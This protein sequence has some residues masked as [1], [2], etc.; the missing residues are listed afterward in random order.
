M[1]LTYAGV[2]G[3]GSGKTTLG[4]VEAGLGSMKI[5][6]DPP[7]SGWTRRVDKVGQTS[8][9]TEM[10][11]ESGD[12]INE[13]ISVYARGINPFASVSY[14]N[15]GNNGG[16]Q[17]GGIQIG[18]PPSAKLPYTIMRDG[19]Y[20]PPVLLQQDL[21][22]LSR[23]PRSIS[24]LSAEARPEMADFTRRLRSCASAAQTK[25]VHTDILHP[26]AQAN[27][28]NP[29]S[30]V[31]AL[32]APFEVKYVVQPTVQKT[33]HSGMRPRGDPT[34][35]WDQLQPGSVQNDPLHAPARTNQQGSNWTSPLNTD[36][37]GGIHTEML[38]GKVRTNQD[39]P[40]GW[41]HSQQLTHPERYLQDPLVH[42][43][44]SN[45][46][47]TT[48]H[49][50]LQSL[51]DLSDLHV[52]EDMVRGSLPTHLSGQGHDYNDHLDPVLDRNLPM[53]TSRT[54]L[55]DG[56]NYQRPWDSD[57]ELHQA[58]NRPTTSF[59]STI[60]PQSTAE[61]PGSTYYSSLPPKLQPGGFQGVPTM[62]RHAREMPQVASTRPSIQH[63][64]VSTVH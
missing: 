52:K 63:F 15:Y 6:R 39:G 4:S 8:S 33:A 35:R 45:L 24:S 38:Q 40:S 43:T 42:S 23:L 47:S 51:M 37:S 17:S 1:T 53:H 25:E 44:A 14:N 58:R 21:L 49:T 19:A 28:S 31:D 10:S 20:R 2:I 56:R 57:V 54:N 12:R 27:L 30:K 26:V 64:A 55:A 62:P 3:S 46:S 50:S 41:A 34:V 48:G 11:D 59:T 13:A 22:P 16:Q 32:K 60:L 9:L 5:L 36:P 18:G 61:N 29:T 7:K